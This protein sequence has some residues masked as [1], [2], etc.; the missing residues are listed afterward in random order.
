MHGCGYFRLIWVAQALARSGH[1][2]TVVYPSTAKVVTP[3]GFREPVNTLK[4][5]VDP[6][7]GNTVNASHPEGV[8]VMVLQRITHKSLAQA[9]PLW[10]AKGIAVVIDIDDDLSSIHPRNPAFAALH[11]KTGKEKFGWQYA[12]EACEAATLVTVST[13]KLLDRYAAHGRGVVLPNCVPQSYLDIPRVD[14]TVIGWGGSVPTHPEDLQVT[15]SAIPRVLDATGTSFTVVGPAVGV[16][17]ALRLQGH[18]W[19][20]TGGVPITAWPRMLADNIGIGIAPLADTLFNSQKSALKILEYSALGIPCVMSPRADYAR[21]HA[22]GI[23]VIAEKPRQ[24]ERALHRY[25]TDDTFRRQ[26]SEMGRAVAANWTIEGNAHRWMDAWRYA[27][28]L[29]DAALW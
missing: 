19:S 18:K 20:A 3:L 17:E 16:E 27:K 15:G 23:G 22:E 12:I 7:T 8:D 14:S 29:Q 26:L 4:G 13:P 24:W 5:K 25:V 21:M 28:E 6:A 11:P 9:V 2:V 10:R 1:D